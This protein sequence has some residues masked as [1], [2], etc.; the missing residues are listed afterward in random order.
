MKYDD[1]KLAESVTTENEFVVNRVGEKPER[2]QRSFDGWDMAILP[3]SLG[4]L[5]SLGYLIYNVVQTVTL[6]GG[7]NAINSILGSIF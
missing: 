1:I 3:L 4:V 2:E 7:I 6:G 5:A